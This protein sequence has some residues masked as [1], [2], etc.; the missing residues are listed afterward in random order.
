MS[1]TPWP[2]HLNASMIDAQLP[3]PLYHQIYLLLRDTIRRGEL[4][5]GAL[6]P[7]E[8]DLADL[9]QV[10]R[11]TVKRALNELATD[12]LV[13]RHRGRGTV[14]TPASQLSVIRGSLEMLI[15]SLK[16]MGDETKVRLVEMAD[17]V[18]GDAIAELLEIGPT[19][20][21]QRAVRLR[22]IEGGPFSYLISYVP[23][24]I[25]RSYTKAELSSVPLLTLLERAGANI[26]EADQ[27]ITAVAAEP[28]IAHAL[29]V[30]TA[31]P[32]LRIERLMRDDSGVPVELI[33]GHYRPDRFVYFIQ[34]RGLSKGSG[35]AAR[36]T[37]VKK[38]A[39]K[40]ARTRVARFEVAFAPIDRLDENLHVFSHVPAFRTHD[41][42]R[43]QDRAAVV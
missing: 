7:G 39:V 36:K 43:E 27:W 23:M 22:T 38:A 5:A 4:P 24:R 6:V 2:A 25:A 13:T 32:L 40:V 21:A 37:P 14:V 18:P 34:Q 16:Q 17:V 42:L 41:G 35:K 1:T 19:E 8:L 31:S 11:I 20:K 33:H 12:S 26:D 28:K 15:D 29:G 3:T 9:F 30:A 10:S